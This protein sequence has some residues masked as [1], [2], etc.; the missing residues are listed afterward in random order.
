MLRVARMPLVQ[1]TL[2]FL[3][4]A[5]EAT[6]AAPP[7]KRARGAQSA[8]PSRANPSTARAAGKSRAK[9]G[10][11]SLTETAAAR[12][13]LASPPDASARSAFAAAVPASVAAAAR[14][15]ARGRFCVG[16][17]FGGVICYHG[18][19]GDGTSMLGPGFL[20]APAVPGAA[21]GVRA[22]VDALGA[23]NARRTFRRAHP[24]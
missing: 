24:T 2:S 1:A 16:V 21:A 15:V 4:S 11:D 3:K 22:L 17:D 19:R 6:P 9:A 12:P 18:T 13:A 5:A 14:G 20:D 7:P 10:E 23:G 8:G